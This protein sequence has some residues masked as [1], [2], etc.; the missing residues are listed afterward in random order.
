MFKHRRRL[1]QENG[2]VHRQEFDGKVVVSG[3][4]VV[5]LKKITSWKGY[6][7][8]SDQRVLLLVGHYFS[9]SRGTRLAVVKTSAV[10]PCIPRPSG[11]VSSRVSLVAVIYLVRLQCPG[12]RRSGRI[13]TRAGSLA[14]LLFCHTGQEAL[15][16]PEEKQQRRQQ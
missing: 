5:W 9:S 6:T 1:R 14:A 4:V 15:K 2:F 16:R 13:R 8:L 10:V 7:K 3:C 12:L 11:R